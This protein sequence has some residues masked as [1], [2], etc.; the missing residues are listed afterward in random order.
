MAPIITRP[1]STC[2]SP[3]FPADAPYLTTATVIH[4]LAPT[5]TVVSIL[6]HPSIPAPIH[7]HGG[8]DSVHMRPT[9]CWLIHMLHP[10]QHHCVLPP[11]TPD[12]RLTRTLST[13][14]THSAPS[15]ALT[16]PSLHYARSQLSSVPLRTGLTS[17]RALRRADLRDRAS[18]TLGHHGRPYHFGLDHP[19]CAPSAALT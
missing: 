2:P 3:M 14:S 9:T 1:R 5:T 10:L 15:A 7:G 16:R 8:V 12:A 19:R 18:T 17:M 13:Y 4:R 11:G 6:L